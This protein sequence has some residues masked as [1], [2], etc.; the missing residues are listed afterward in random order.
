MQGPKLCTA[1]PKASIVLS[2]GT[3]SGGRRTPN[4]AGRA[5]VPLG[6][7]I[8]GPS[9]QVCDAGGVRVLVRAA[10]AVAGALVVVVGVP[11]SFAVLDR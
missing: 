10:I 11:G 3:M 1:R 5:S 9:G 8:F 2:S 4:D 7:A 6:R